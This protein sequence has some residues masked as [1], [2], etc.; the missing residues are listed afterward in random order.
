M[1]RYAILV[2]ILLIM[3]VTMAE[4]RSVHSTSEV[5]MF[6]QGTMQVSDDWEFN[7]HLAF[8]A[9]DRPDD[10]DYVMGMIAD[11][12]MTLGINLP[13]HLDDQMIWSSTTSTNSNASI[14][15]PDGA[16]SWSTGPDIT[17]SGFDVSSF[18]ENTIESVELIVHFNIPDPL[19]QDKARFSVVN[20]GIHDLVKTW[21]NTQG[22]LYYM[23]NGWSVEIFDDNNWT[24]DELSNIDINLDYVSNGGTDD[25]QLQVDA[26]GLKITLF[27]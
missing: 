3:P 2:L 11:N 21:S 17:L 6:P 13:E 27:L 16:Y 12:H 19:T 10:A 23:T 14:G 7:R 8:T 22:G 18:G 5:E 1:R 9:E 26:V 25:S 20:N 15:T 4:A 24:W